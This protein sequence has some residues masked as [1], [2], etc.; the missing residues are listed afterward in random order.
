VSYPSRLK[1]AGSGA[2]TSPMRGA[3]GFSEPSAPT[4]SPRRKGSGG[5]RPPFVVADTFHFAN[6]ALCAPAYIQQ[7]MLAVAWRQFRWASFVPY[8]NF[9]LL[10]MLVSPLLLDGYMPL[11]EGAQQ[12]YDAIRAS[13]SEL[14]RRPAVQT[15]MLTDRGS[16]DD[17][18]T[19]NSHSI[20]NNRNVFL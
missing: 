8:E 16:P 4:T 19:G 5:L 2:T 7:N 1:I 10:A 12:A 11:V 20:H 14:T 13:R 17:A 9:F 3:T 6:R 18:A 15:I